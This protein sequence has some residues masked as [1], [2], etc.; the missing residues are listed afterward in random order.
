MDGPD[1]GVGAVDD[2]GRLGDLVEVVAAVERLD[3]GPL[4]PGPQEEHATATVDGVPVEASV[5][6]LVL[7]QQPPPSG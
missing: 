2:P 5:P 3:S 1:P 7:E 4:G 6:V